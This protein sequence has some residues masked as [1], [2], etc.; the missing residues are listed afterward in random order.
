MSNDDQRT[1][2]LAGSDHNADL[3]TRCRD[4]RLQGLTI[5]A[6]ALEA[7]RIELRNLA[8]STRGRRQRLARDKAPRPA[9]DILLD[10]DRSI[11]DEQARVDAALVRLRR[12]EHDEPR[13]VLFGKTKA[14]KTTLRNALVGGDGDGIG[15][16]QQ[17]A[18]RGAT[19]HAW[20]NF[21]LFDTPGTAALGG[22]EDTEIALEAARQ[23]DLVIYLADDDALREEEVRAIGKL[24][25]T[26][27][28]VVLALNVKFDLSRP[29][30]LKRFLAD[31]KVAF[32][33]D[34]IVGH[35]NRIQEIARRIGSPF[36]E[37]VAVH[38]QAAFLAGQPEY[39][40]S[41]DVLREQSRV[42]AL[43]SAIE[44]AVG[45]VRAPALRLRS[46]VDR[47][48]QWLRCAAN[49]LDRVRAEVRA[50]Q[51]P[52]QEISDQLRLG[53]KPHLGVLR[54]EAVE[55]PEEWLRPVRAD[56]AS[57]LEA[58]I[59][60][61]DVGRMWEERFKSFGIAEKARSWQEGAAKRV[62]AAANDIEIDLQ[63]VGADSFHAGQ[64]QRF[65][66]MDWRHTARVASAAI[67]VAGTAIATFVTGGAAL[68]AFLGVVGTIGGLGSGWVPKRQERRAQACDDAKKKLLDHLA[69][70][71]ERLRQSLSRWVAEVVLARI[72][73]SVRDIER[74]ADELSGQ[75]RELL[76]SI[77]ALWQR[78]DDAD[79]ALL[80]GLMDRLALSSLRGSVIRCARSPG[81]A[82][83][84]L[85][86]G[87]FDRATCMTLE[88]VLSEGLHVILAGDDP[89]AL[90][91]A[92]LQ[93][94]E[95]D[96][97][98]VKISTDGV[99]VAV[100]PSGLVAAAGPDGANLRTASRLLKT[101]ISLLLAA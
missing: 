48:T 7:S 51:G 5:G 21:V 50:V 40:A 55:L 43:L 60:A 96:S 37:P 6:A 38:A 83:K 101:K 39:A 25:T 35:R 34:Q 99:F 32:R 53:L 84:I 75:D 93:P 94:A 82:T 18:S 61:A 63:E 100:G 17:R 52:L 92:S 90:V 72:E 30:N 24:Q 11:A 26:G 66:G 69:V 80:L 64:V 20:G 87:G 23:A 36:V 73:Q 44:A 45:G 2:C 4:A 89:A 13:V 85:A 58:N 8:N 1:A 9:Q 29:L 41:R 68:G 74:V 78:V 56:V 65:G 97:N 28:P 77:E 10:L 81:A 49:A 71:E 31:P 33:P 70:V 19:A 42:D 59:E 27:V 67:V 62:L 57:F 46:T 95:L 54:R 15:R 16:G 14:G 91:S 22:Q 79:T 76:R 3:L 88:A 47:S 86:R 98:D 12:N